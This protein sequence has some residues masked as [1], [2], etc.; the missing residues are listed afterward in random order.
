MLLRQIAMKIS[1]NLHTI[2][3]GISLNC[4]RISAVFDAA[5]AIPS[6][7]RTGVGRCVR[8]VPWLAWIAVKSCEILNTIREGIY[9]SFV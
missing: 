4:P 1:E 2:R 3:G 9:L 8:G 7:C 6:H 5:R